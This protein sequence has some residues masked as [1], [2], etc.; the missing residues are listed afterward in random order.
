MWSPGIE[1]LVSCGCAQPLSLVS[2]PSQFYCIFLTLIPKDHIPKW[3]PAHKPWSEDLLSQRMRGEEI[4]VFQVGGGVEQWSSG[5]QRTE[6]WARLSV[7]K[8]VKVS[9]KRAL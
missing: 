9:K 5:G 8:E 2:L 7:P 6:G 4:R 1:H 3:Q